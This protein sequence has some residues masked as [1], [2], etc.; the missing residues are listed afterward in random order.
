VGASK[1]SVG[2]SK[3]SVGASVATDEG[4]GCDR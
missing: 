1:A 3:A 2:A 4:I